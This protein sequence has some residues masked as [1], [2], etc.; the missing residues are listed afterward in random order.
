M[1]DC[2]EHEHDRL[3]RWLEDAITNCLS[4]SIPDVYQASSA[5]GAY[6]VIELLTGSQYR[7]F[8][9]RIEVEDD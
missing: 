2:Y 7:V 6:L 3:V 5:D 4:S 1:N 8:V 9:E